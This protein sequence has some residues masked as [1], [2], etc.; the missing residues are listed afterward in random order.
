MQLIIKLLDSRV[1]AKKHALF[2]SPYINKLIVGFAREPHSCLTQPTLLHFAVWIGGNFMRRCIIILTF[3]RVIHCY[4][5]RFGLGCRLGQARAFF[6]RGPNTSYLILAPKPTTT[7]C[8]VRTRTHSC[9]T[10][11]TLL[12]F[13]VWIGGNFMR[14]A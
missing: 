5:L 12:H 8:W 6:P 3:I 10:Q 2:F 13:A 14:V 11:P 7:K 1:H 9:L 4:I